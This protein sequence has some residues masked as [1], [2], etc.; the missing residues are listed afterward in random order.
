MRS[1]SLH[2]DLVII[3]AGSFLFRTTGLTD[4]EVG[5]ILLAISL[6]LLCGCLVCIVKVLN[7][8]LKGIFIQ[9]LS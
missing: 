9:F 7:S 5:L 4:A 3:N 6:I 8:M 1:S 2:R